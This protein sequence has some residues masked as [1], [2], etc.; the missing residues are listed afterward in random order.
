LIAG[1]GAGDLLAAAGAC[2]GGALV[3]GPGRD[4][5]SF[6]EA[7]AHP[8]VMVAS[9]TTDRAFVRALPNCR[10]VR[11]HP[12]AED[13]EGT[14]DWD[15]LI[16]DERGNALLGQP[17][18]DRFYGLGGRDQVNAYDRERDFFIDCGKAG[19]VVL[20]DRRDPKA[21]RCEQGEITGPAA[22]LPRLPPGR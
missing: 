22:E 11:I 19:G 1:Q 2:L 9:L 13:L 7:P 3:G 6:A 20:D 17:G 5:A 21:H 10:P 12:T 16:G 14:F 4:N 18:R 15:I 8:G